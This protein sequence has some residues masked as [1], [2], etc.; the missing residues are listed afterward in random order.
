MEAGGGH[1]D[2]GGALTREDE[3]ER[4]GEHQWEEGELPGG[5]VA[6]AEGLR[7]NLHG[8]LWHAERR[9]GELGLWL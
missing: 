8:E 2:G 1:G 4:V 3:W 5:A 9:G 7:G 6:A